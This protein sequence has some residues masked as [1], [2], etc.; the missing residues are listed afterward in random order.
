MMKFP[1]LQEW[2]KFFCHYHECTFI[3]HKMDSCLF[4]S[5]SLFQAAGR[6]SIM[7]RRRK[8]PNPT[9]R[10]LLSQHLRICTC[11]WHTGHLGKGQVA[12]IHAEEVSAQD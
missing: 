10:L 2:M 12:E 1:S 6:R 11:S 5:R 3:Y 7:T 8:E 4:I 9:R